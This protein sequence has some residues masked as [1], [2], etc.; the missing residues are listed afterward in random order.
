[1][2]GDLSAVS[3]ETATLA[4][5]SGCGTR[6]F[7]GVAVSAEISLPLVT[8]KNI[9]FYYQKYIFLGSKYPKIKKVNSEKKIFTAAHASLH[10]PPG[11]PLRLTRHAFSSDNLCKI[12]Y[13][14]LVKTRVIDVTS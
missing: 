2:W 6:L 5:T 14:K 8:P 1:M 12:T 10:P 11:T 13:L 7:I 9:Y 4:I 3:A